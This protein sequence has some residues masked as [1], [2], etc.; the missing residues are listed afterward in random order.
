MMKVDANLINYPIFKY[1]FIKGNK[2]LTVF[3]ADDRKHFSFSSGAS[4]DIGSPI[5]AVGA[6]VDVEYGG[7]DGPKIDLGMTFG[8]IDI[9]IA[10]D[11]M[12][13]ESGAILGIGKGVKGS[14]L[15]GLESKFMIYVEKIPNNDIDAWYNKK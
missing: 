11:L 13:K 12:N 1:D 5:L 8:P 4:F 14:F 9:D 3:S 15:I 2:L 7:A 6:G 10:K